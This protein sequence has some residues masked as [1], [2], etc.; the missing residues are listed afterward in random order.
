MPRVHRQDFAG[1]IRSVTRTPQGGLRVPAAVTR[2]GVLRYQDHEGRSWWEYRPP[3]EVFAA[4]SL[5]SL[6][7]APVTD[8]H[9]PGKV[10]AETWEA[11]AKGH[12]DSAPT[13]EDGLVVVD[14]AVQAAPLVGLVE[15]GDRRDTSCG[16]DCEVDWTPGVT[17]E[18]EAYD[19]VQR[20]IRYNHVALL[21]PGHGRAGTD[22]ALR[23]DGAAFE[24]SAGTPAAKGNP[25]KKKLKIGGREFRVDADEEV[26]AAQGAI[27][28]AIEKKDEE[29]E[30]IAAE[31]KATKEA[32]MQALTT[33][34]KL[35][36]KLAAAEAV[37]PAAPEVTEEMVPE[38]VQDAI[39]AKRG[40]LIERAR[41][42]LGPEVKL[43]GLSAAEIH[44]K[45]VSKAHPALRLDGLSADTVQG[46]FAILAEQHEARAA[47]VDQL[48]RVL[49]P[50]AEQG[51]AA[52]R[53][54]A[55]DAVDHSKN[56]QNKIVE[57]GR[58]PI[59]GGGKAA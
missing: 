4:D 56:L 42:V 32:L 57:M 9:P 11:L 6:R 22:V 17:P 33:V 35:E 19:A 51:A 41:K 54:D 25:M 13:R 36:A 30:G 44:R 47:S 37:K 58:Q 1:P 12:V 20:G 24:V 2:T 7:A 10:T 34:A 23:M 55:Q 40:A 16:Y 21:P 15:T 49:A 8:L 53:T 59:N 43:D 38:T 39:V 29:Q 18:G 14:L 26:E 31:L 50:S 3:E 28:Q 45:A 5:A 48:G 52:A 46:M 27:D